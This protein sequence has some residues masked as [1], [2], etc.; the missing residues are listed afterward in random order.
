MSLFLINIGLSLMF[1]T[2]VSMITYALHPEEPFWK[3]DSE[4][5]IHVHSRKGE[6]TFVTTLST[7][8]VCFIATTIIFNLFH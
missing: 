6:E 8:F 2:G 1:S 7:F 5:K 3:E 4:G